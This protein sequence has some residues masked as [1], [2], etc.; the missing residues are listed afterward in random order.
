[1]SEI[2]ARAARA[3]RLLEDPDLKRAFKDVQDAIY[4]LFHEL[5]P[6][7]TEALLKCRERLHLLDSVIANIKQ[8]IRDGELARYRAEEQ[9]RPPLLGDLLSW[10][11][12]KR[13]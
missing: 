11:K 10:R 5:Q 8:A 2:D 3:A 6:T 1:M 7:E 12:N 9:E 13:A 4:R